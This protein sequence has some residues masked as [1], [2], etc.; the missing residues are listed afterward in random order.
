MIPITM[1]ILFLFLLVIS[2]TEHVEAANNTSN[3]SLLELVA[4]EIKDG[5]INLIILDKNN[6]I[7]FIVIEMSKEK[8][9]SNY[10]SLFQILLIL[11]PSILGVAATKWVVN[12]W[13]MRND[14]LKTK[15]E[16]LAEFD[17]S[18]KSLAILIDN[19]IND[20]S[21]DNEAQKMFI[22]NLK[23]IRFVF[24]SFISLNFKLLQSE[25]TR[26]HTAHIP[27]LG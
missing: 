10:D 21:K 9:N 19:Y 7:Q 24:N 5:E 26:S 8:S 23:E 6:E 3:E 12:D 22:K 20:S 11:I 18:T 13:Q 4:S 16:I 15:K 14:L 27:P 25:F 2:N 1:V 17:K